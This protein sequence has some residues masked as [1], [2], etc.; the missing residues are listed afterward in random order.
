MNLYPSFP[1]LLLESGEI[2]YKKSA[3]N[4]VENLSLLTFPIQTLLPLTPNRYICVPAHIPNTSPA[5]PNTQL[6]HLCPCS[7]SQY[8]PCYP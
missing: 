8:K 7:H 3:H 4:V 1:Y 2:R 5:T 6:P